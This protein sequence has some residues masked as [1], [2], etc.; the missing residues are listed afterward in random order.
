MKFCLRIHLILNN[1]HLPRARTLL[2]VEQISALQ[3]RHRNLRIISKS[4][5]IVTMNDFVEFRTH[6][7]IY[8]NNTGVVR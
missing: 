6:H 1:L 2:V 5:Q 4:S 8:L 3:R 7:A